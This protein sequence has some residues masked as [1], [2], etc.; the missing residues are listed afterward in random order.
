MRSEASST[1]PRRFCQV[2]GNRGQQLQEVGLGVVGAAE[3]RP[4]VRGEETR[5]G[6]AALARQ[7]DGGVHVDRV[8]VGPFLAVDLD[9]DESVVHHGGDGL[10][11]E[12]LVRHHVTPVA[13]RVPDRQQDRHV[14]RRRLRQ[15]LRRPLL[16]VH[17][18]VGVLAQV[19]AGGQRQVVSR[20]AHGSSHQSARRFDGPI[21]LIRV[22]LTRPGALV[23]EGLRQ[24]AQVPVHRPDQQERAD[25]QQHDDQQAE[26]A[27][28]AEVRSRIAGRVLRHQPEDGQRGVVHASTPVRPLPCGRGPTGPRFGRELAVRPIEV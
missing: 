2:C 28:L 19:R 17:R 8:D 25:Q 1:S 7:R 10:V 5:H 26:R 20:R 12:R 11:L 18:V 4:A 13:G 21:G 6:P 15:C 3:E 14:P 22:G 27:G 16:P 9:V 24:L 23:V